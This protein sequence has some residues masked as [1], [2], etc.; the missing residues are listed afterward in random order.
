MAERESV[1]PDKLRTR[2]EL[3]DNSRTPPALSLPVP[4]L[5]PIKMSGSDGQYTVTVL[6]SVC[7]CDA[8]K[9]MSSDIKQYIA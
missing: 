4:V 8:Y 2:R 3:R 1:S 5:I 7:L 9:K 6:S